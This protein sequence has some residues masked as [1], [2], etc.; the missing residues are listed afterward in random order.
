MSTDVGMR[1]T[2]R[3]T[4][5]ARVSS[6]PVI[7]DAQPKERTVGPNPATR[8]YTG[9]EANAA[10]PQAAGCATIPLALG[11]HPVRGKGRSPP[12]SINFANLLSARCADAGRCY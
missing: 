12:V 11:A 3:V 4:L 1:V 2:S 7:L 9:T 6:G 8:W 10:P 5:C